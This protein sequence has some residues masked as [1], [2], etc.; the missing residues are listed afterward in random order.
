MKKVAEHIEHKVVK[1]FTDCA[2]EQVNAILFRDVDTVGSTLGY[3][4]QYVLSGEK[5]NH[6]DADALIAHYQN[7]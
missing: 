4:L 3:M 5:I 2:S 7:S 6:H 1:V